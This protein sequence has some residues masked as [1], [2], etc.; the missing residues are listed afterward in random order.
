[1]CGPEPREARSAR[2]GS[3]CGR[4]RRPPSAARRRPAAAPRTRAARPEK[5]PPRIAPRS[6]MWRTSARVSTPVIAGTPQSSSQSSQPP[7]AVAQSSPLWASRMITA[8]ACAASDSI[9]SAADPVVADQRVGEGDDL[10]GVGGVGDRLLVAGHRGV[11][12]DLAAAAVGRRVDRA[13]EL[14]VEARAVLE[15]DVA[16]RGSRRAT[17]GRGAGPP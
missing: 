12:D 4:S 5:I 1:M 17:P 9:A 8:R 7:S 11:E 13:A 15:Q 2:P 14:A 16:G 10:A 3:P 6:R